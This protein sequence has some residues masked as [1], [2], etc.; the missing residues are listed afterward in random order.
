MRARGRSACPNRE[1]I[2]PPGSDGAAAVK[3]APRVTTP[4]CGRRA[5]QGTGVAAS[6]SS[7]ERG[8]MIFRVL[9]YLFLMLG[10]AIR[11]RVVRIR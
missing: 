6:V 5:R 9:L 1:N 3:R 7:E 4:T 8:R 2:F 11:E 10:L